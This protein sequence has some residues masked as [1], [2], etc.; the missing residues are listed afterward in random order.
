[1]GPKKSVLTTIIEHEWSS[2]YV[3]G[4][5]KKF[6]KEAMKE[7]LTFGNSSAKAAK[8]LTDTKSVCPAAQ[9]TYQAD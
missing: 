1:M 2:V 6:R 7:L 9:K 5:P 4:L 3:S 8:F